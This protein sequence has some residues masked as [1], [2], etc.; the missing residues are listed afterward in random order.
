MKQTFA[1]DTEKAHR[2]E[3]GTHCPVGKRLLREL[4]YEVLV[5]HEPKVQLIS[6][7]ANRKDDRQG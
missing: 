5:A 2:L 1:K 7:E 3:T 4:G 6:I